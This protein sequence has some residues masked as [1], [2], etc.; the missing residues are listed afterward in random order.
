MVGEKL[1]E[2]TFKSLLINFPLDRKYF[3][4]ILW[5][6]PLK[7][8]GKTG[9]KTLQKSCVKQWTKP[10]IYRARKISHWGLSEL[11]VDRP[12]VIFQT[13]VSFR[14]T[15]RS[16]ENTREQTALSQ[17]TGRSTGLRVIQRA[18]IRA[19]RSTVAVDRLHGAVD[20]PSLATPVQVRKTCLF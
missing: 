12:T 3:L 9:S 4:F 19:R 13:V 17:S 2:I 7:R 15:A 10:Q 6:K 14:S 5:R 1:K 16:T 8:I 11:A 18:R 20:R